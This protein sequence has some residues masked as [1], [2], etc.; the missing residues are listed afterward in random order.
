MFGE[1]TAVFVECVVLIFINSCFFKDLFFQWKYDSFIYRIVN[2]V[3][4]D[5]LP[6]VEDADDVVKYIIYRVT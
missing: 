2:I 3:M 6:L 4:A 5:T 1:A